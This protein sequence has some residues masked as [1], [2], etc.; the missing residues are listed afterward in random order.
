MKRIVKIVMLLAVY[1]VWICGNAAIALTCNAHTLYAS[2][3]NHYGCCSSCEC[4]H[5]GHDIVHVETPHK[6]HH[7]HSNTIA[8]YDATKKNNL[9]IEPIVLSITAQIE[10]NL[11]IEEVVLCSSQHYERK[12]PI[13]TAPTLSRRGLRAPPVVA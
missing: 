10:D 1:L 9:N 7:D 13:P 2:N 6:C 3:H 12:T 4:H 5:E 8:L 11:R